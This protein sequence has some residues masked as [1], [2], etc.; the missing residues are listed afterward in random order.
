MK[1]TATV[2]HEFTLNIDMQYVEKFII[3]YVQNSNNVFV[4]TETDIDK[5]IEI[6]SNTIIIKFTQEDTKK[7]IQG[8]VDVEIKLYTKNKK[9]LINENPLKVYVQDVINEDLFDEN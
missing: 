4:F 2:E 5:N 7:F 1:R 3:T 8:W 6:N 9:V